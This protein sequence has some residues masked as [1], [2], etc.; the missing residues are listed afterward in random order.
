M[1]TVIVKIATNI[2]KHMLRFI[3]FFL[4]FL[5]TDNNKILLCSRQG[6]YEPLDFVLIR[7]KLAEIL[8]GIECVVICRHIGHDIKD[9]AVYLY[10]LF[11]SMYHMATCRLCVIDSY[12]PAVSLLKHKDNL[13]VIQIWHAI[14]KVKKS[15]Y[16]TIGMRSGRKSEYS[17]ILN[18]HEN[19]DYVIAGAEMWTP[20]YCES[21]NIAEE[22]ILN[23]GLP[24]ID[25]LIN[26]E[27]SNKEKFREQFPQWAGKQIILYAPT[28]RRNM[29]TQWHDIQQSITNNDDVILIIKKHPGQI[30][31][32][33]S[34]SDNTISLDS[35]ETIDLLSVCDYLITDYSAIAL[36]AMVLRKKTYYWVYDYEK[37]IE[38]N[39]LNIDLFKEF[40][41]C[42]FNDIYELMK[43]I[44]NDINKEGAV[45]SNCEKYLPKD[46][47]NATN[48]IAGLCADILCGKE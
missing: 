18:M 20:Y 14:G 28:F 33:A 10:A 3:Y 26:T 21:F 48:K 45:S 46:L 1:K 47:G 30:K 38:N 32:K 17:Q 35:W 41:G 23:F 11:K 9:Y 13:K 44:K 25:Y 6:N 12:W 19:Y 42:V 27:E 8:P 7:Q 22:K 24:R 29:K 31:H 40:P 2:F 36:E 4:K 16:Q 34:G 39:G 43:E 15:G 37:Y 5:P